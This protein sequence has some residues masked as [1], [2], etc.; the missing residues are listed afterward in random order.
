[1]HQ[2]DSKIIEANLRPAPQSASSDGRL[3]ACACAGMTKQKGV[4]IVGETPRHGQV[5]VH[6]GDLPWVSYLDVRGLVVY[7]GLHATSTEL[8]EFIRPG[9]GASP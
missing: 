6:H 3:H 5:P 4:S 9:G 2:L 7:G 1:M 8:R